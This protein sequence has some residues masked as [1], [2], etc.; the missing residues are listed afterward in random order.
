[1]SG[2]YRGRDLL[3]ESC[4]PPLERVQGIYLLLGPHNPF[5]QLLL[6]DCRVRFSMRAVFDLRKES[7]QPGALL[8]VSGE[9]AERAPA[10]LIPLLQASPFLPALLFFFTLMCLF[11]QFALPLN[12]DGPGRHDPSDNL[13]Q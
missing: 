7:Q 12:Q 5:A 3:E 8:P 11:L 6:G 9:R 13:R 2:W 1:M 10:M 4:D